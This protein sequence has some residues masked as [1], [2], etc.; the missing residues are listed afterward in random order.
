M[1]LIFGFRPETPASSTSCLACSLFLF[2]SMNASFLG[3]ND[4]RHSHLSR[5]WTCGVRTDTPGALPQI[6]SGALRLLFQ[7]AGCLV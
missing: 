3:H 1:R 2:P 5:H 6:L 4:R 7:Q